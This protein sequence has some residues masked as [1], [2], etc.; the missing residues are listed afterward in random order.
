MLQ[1]PNWNLRDL[2]SLN[3]P[4]ASSKQL[5]DL[6]RH[7]RHLPDVEAMTL[8]QGISHAHRR[9]PQQ[10][11][12][13]KES[14]KELKDNLRTDWDYPP[15][16]AFQTPVRRSGGV[17]DDVDEVEER[18]AGFKFHT[19][20]N[21]RTSVVENA[22][23]APAL[24]FEPVAWREREYSSES[25]EETESVATA[26]SGGS[27]KSNYKFEGPDSVGAQL[28]DR[29]LARKRKRKHLL[30]E[31][32]AC[33][34]GLAHWLTRR[35]AWCAAHTP[36]QVQMFESRERE[37]TASVSASA[38]ASATTT[39]RTSTSSTSSTSA[40]LSSPSTTPE[41]PVQSV[42]GTRPPAP[43]SEILIPVAPTL[44]AN[45]PIRKKIKPD[46]YP[47]IYSKII[48]QSR[49]PS[50]PINLSVLMKALI[51][52]W[53]D[54]GEWPPKQGP[55]EKSIGRKKSS[56]HE[57]SLKSSVKA[58]AKVLRITGGESSHSSREKG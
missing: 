4:T 49:T 37:P 26:S 42:I 19:P 36:Q 25:S 28:Q 16:P 22:A 24:Y 48:L 51:Q 57:S 13:I 46:V 58:V 30:E 1:S 40:V 47:E 55:I 45:H 15:L 10:Q 17:G 56:G 18:V 9:N 31:E 8:H 14:K 33:N 5:P 39:P 7:L 41:I 53:K 11:Q 6:T 54:D 34:D 3:S 12:Q 2:T 50:V 52:G 20:A 23:E 38:S 43:P 27:K 21:Y 44:F 35:D 29:K 32:T